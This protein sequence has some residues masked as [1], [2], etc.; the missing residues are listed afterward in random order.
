MILHSLSVA[1]W[2]SLL[3]PVEL[4]PFSDRLNVIH[5]PNGTGKSSLFEA[6]RRA[7][8]DAHHVSGEEIGAVRPWG[9]SLAPQVKVEFTQSGVR[10]RVEKTFLDGA[11]ARLFRFEEGK[12]RPLADSR[13]ADSKLREI[14]YP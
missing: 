4:G 14:I 5:A 10:Y 12:F 11:S 13:N 2:R 8:F 9:R 3:N 1:N 7:L 6:M